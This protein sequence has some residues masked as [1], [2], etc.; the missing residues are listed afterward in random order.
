MSD[1]TDRRNGLRIV[2][3]ARRG[4]SVETIREQLLALTP[5]ARTLVARAG[6]EPATFRCSDGSDCGTSS[7]VLVR[8]DTLDQQADVSASGS[9]IDGG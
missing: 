9:E 7:F 3:T 1:L 5:L 2:V 8:P 4:H 6:I